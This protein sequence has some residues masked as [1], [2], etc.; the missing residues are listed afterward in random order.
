MNTCHCRYRELRGRQ[1]FSLH[2]R[3]RFVIKILSLFCASDG[4]K[5]KRLGHVETGRRAHGILRAPQKFMSWIPN[6]VFLNRRA[7]RGSTEIY[8][9]S[10]LSNFH[11]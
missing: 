6:P 7:A 8:H 4:K 2:L 9:F 3:T 10:F 1:N 11:E 5:K